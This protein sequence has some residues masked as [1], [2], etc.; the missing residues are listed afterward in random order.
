MISDLYTITLADGTVTDRFTSTDVAVIANSLRYTPIPIQRNSIKESVGVQ[1]GEM[2]M[3]IYPDPTVTAGG[4]P[5]LQ[6]VLSGVLDGARVKLERGYYTDW[7][8]TAVGTL[9]RFSGRIADAKITRT[10]AIITVASDLKLLDMQLPRNLYMPTCVHTLFDSGCT[11]N[12]AS[13]KVTGTVSSGSTSTIVNTNATQA[14]AYFALGTI[15][16]TNGINAGL[17]RGVKSF[18]HT[19]GVFTLSAP[20]A[21]PPGTGDAWDAYPGDDKKQTT[22]VNKFNNLANYRG[23]DYIPIPETAV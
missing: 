11:L 13:F 1:V 7:T 3:E 19:G 22:C 8:Q 4:L 10:S 12:K 21:A 5:F 18:V 14:D 20:L 2:E 6:A 17:I 15:K 9:L 23:Y 16:F